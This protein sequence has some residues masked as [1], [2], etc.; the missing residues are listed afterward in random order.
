MKTITTHNNK[1][2]VVIEVPDNF[3]YNPYNLLDP[4]NNV[5]WGINESI[6]EKN[7]L[8]LEKQ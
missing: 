4:R 3:L 5:L 8:I 2:I 6:V 7:L 1:E